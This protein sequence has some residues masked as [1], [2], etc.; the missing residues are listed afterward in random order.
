[1]P[2]TAGTVLVVDDNV[3]HAELLRVAGERVAPDLSFQAVLDGQEA[4]DYLDGI[5][6]FHDRDLHP[7]PCLVLLDLMMPRLDG[8]GVLARLQNVRWDD[9]VPIVVLTT[10]LNPVDESRAMALGADAFHTK[11]AGVEGLGALFE[12]IVR[13]W[14]I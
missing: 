10:S 14:L 4:L 13:R 8:F 7:Y 5:P 1:M 11:P 3:D 12:D 9:P 6:P 2:D